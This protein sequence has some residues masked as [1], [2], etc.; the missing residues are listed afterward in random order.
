[1]H[2]PRHSRLM[3]K[4][5]PR[6]VL[7]HRSVLGETVPQYAECFPGLHDL[8][9]LHA[10]LSK[11]LDV[12]TTAVA[13]LIIS[14]ILNRSARRTAVKPEKALGLR[15]Q[16]QFQYHHSR[17]SCR[18]V[19]VSSC[20][21]SDIHIYSSFRIEFTYMQIRIIIENVLKK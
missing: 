16:L 7:A 5:L 11:A 17:S 10:T 9:A 4:N 15:S 3:H 18:W 13:Q 19:P 14:A 20:F 12:E 1:V 8:S 21:R 2:L 6:G